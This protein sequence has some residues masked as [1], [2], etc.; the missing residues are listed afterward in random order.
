MTLT[1]W[2][3][4]GLVLLAISGY[5]YY[6]SQQTEKITNATVENS[7]K[8][9]TYKSQHMVSRVYDLAGHLNYYLVSDNVEHYATQGETQ[10]TSPDMTLYDDKHQPNWHIKSNHATLT[11]DKMLLLYGKVDVNS[12][13]SDSELRKIKGSNVQINLVNRDI[14]SEDEITLYGMTFTAAGRRLEGNLAT[15]AAKLYENVNTYFG[16]KDE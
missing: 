4:L 8:G 7:L 2:H 11:Q 5:I 12:L 1:K 6:D 15:K 10:F 13:V 9:P 3:Y 16:T 14:T